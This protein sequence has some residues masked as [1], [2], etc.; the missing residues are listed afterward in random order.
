MNYNSLLETLF[1][2]PEHVGVP[3]G[4]IPLVACSRI[5]VKK[6]ARFD[7]CMACE[8]SGLVKKACFKAYG[9]PYL[10][11]GLEWLCRQVE[12]TMILRPFIL[13]HQKLVELLAIPKSR[14]PDALLIAE[15]YREVLETMKNLLG[16]KQ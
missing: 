7:F 3:D 11:A 5:R 6:G 15:S 10:V 16:D 2:K 9:N 1:F 14:H 13:D 8:P 12:G 4:S